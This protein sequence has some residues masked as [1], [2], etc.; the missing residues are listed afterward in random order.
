MTGPRPLALLESVVMSTSVPMA[1]S[2]P[3][4]DVD[5][6][7]IYVNESFS[8]VFGYASD[9]IVGLPASITRAAEMDARTLEAVVAARRRLEPIT[10]EYPGRRKNGEVFWCE[11]SLS[12][13]FADDGACVG[14]V[15]ILNDISA[16]RREERLLHDRS[17][18]LETIAN[19]EPLSVVFEAIV[20]AAERSLPGVSAS[21]SV[22]R[23]DMLEIVS[24]GPWFRAAADGYDLVYPIS[25]AFAPCSTAVS[26]G[27]Q[28]TSTAVRDV[29]GRYGE[30]ARAAGIRACVATPIRTANGETIGSFAQ[31]VYGDETTVAD[32]QHYGY[33][34]AHLA[35]I[36]SERHDDRERL[37]FLA[38]HD[39][40]TGLPNRMFFEER[41]KL[42]IAVALE[43]ATNVAVA[44]FDLDRF[45]V[46]DDSLGHAAGDALLRAV[47]ERFRR[48]ARPADAVARLSGDEFAVVLEGVPD[49]DAAERIVRR[50]LEALSPS[51]TIGHEEV[52]IRARA[53]LALYPSDAGDATTLL[54]ASAAALAVTRAGAND[55]AFFGDVMP[56]PSDGAASGIALETSLRHAFERDE[57]AVLFQPIVDLRSRTVR[58]AE[59]LLRWNHPAAGETLP[60]AFIGAAEATGLILPLG[61]WAIEE[62]CR[63]ARRWQDEGSDRFVAVNVSARQ[64]DRADFVE[65]ILEILGR[66]GLEP[67]RLHLE[68]TESLVMR[69]PEEA[70][71]RLAALKALGIGLSIDDFGTGYSSFMYLKRFPV[72]G[73]KID[74][75]FVRDVGRGTAGAADEAIVRAI[76]GVAE[77][78]GLR[79]VAEGIESEE[80]AAFIAE[81]GV[82][83][84]Q[85]FLFA[86]AL[87]PDDAAGWLRCASSA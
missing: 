1:I 4:D 10:V 3:D 83:L 66:T 20:A 40:L 21:I 78:L 19:D 84:G 11:V 18:V 22:R 42:A 6:K 32:A 23:G 81:A 49:R 26:S 16:R 33:E 82:H 36:A 72:D 41:V 31:H 61:A 85:G 87:R 51:F 54:I 56:A 35:A 17:H 58:G 2:A 12:P 57:F 62:A 59:A 75:L 60:D 24:A 76:V 68:L 7:I 27:E 50:M 44:T 45:K 71:A 34:L 80:Q 77:A 69:C 30:I 13:L 79:V 47:G 15:S 5:P 48:T 70:A 67:R 39:A 65:T 52:F 73:L 9:E 63:F 28:Q 25:E 46:V 14:F 37:E 38:R 43:R 55:V 29:P 8:R 64:F 86:P 53:G 74:R